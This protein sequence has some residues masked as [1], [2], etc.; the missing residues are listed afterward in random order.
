MDHVD[1]LSMHLTIYQD[2]IAQYK[3]L[4]MMDT[5]WSVS[6]IVKLAEDK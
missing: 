5:D 6:S 2:S 4:F 3:N 1:S